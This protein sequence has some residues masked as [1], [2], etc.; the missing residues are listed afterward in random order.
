M[1]SRNNFLNTKKIAISVFSILALFCQS[2]SGEIEIIKKGGVL[3]VSGTVEDSVEK[4]QINFM[5]SRNKEISFYHEVSEFNPAY[6]PGSDEGYTSQWDIFYPVVDMALTPNMYGVARF[7]EPQTTVYSVN[8]FFFPEQLELDSDQ[9]KIENGKLL[10]WENNVYLDECTSPMDSFYLAEQVDVSNTV[11]DRKFELLA[12]DWSGIIEVVSLPDKKEILRT[13]ILSACESNRDRELHEPEG[14]SLNR[15]RLLKSLTATIDFTLRSQ[16]KSENSRAK[17]GLNLFY[18]LKAKTFRRPTWIW[19]WGPSIKLLLDAE[20]IPEISKSYSPGCLAD[21]AKE[22]GETTLKFQENDVKSPAF[23]LIVSRWS[24]T[25]DTLIQ[26]SGYEKYY[27]VADAQFLAGW[28]WM[29]LYERTKDER[30]L[31]GTRRLT[32]ATER[33]MKEHDFLPMDYKVREGEWKNYA[34]NEQG[35]GTLATAELH[36]VEP[37]ER[38]QQIV[39]DYM[40]MLSGKFES[41]SGLWNRKVL[42][43]ENEIIPTAYKPK[44]QGWVAEGL[45]AVYETTQDKTYLLKAEKI[46]D[47]LVEYQLPEGAWSL[48]FTEKDSSHIDEKA[49]AIWSFLFYRLYHHTEDATY[50]AA[51]RK[52]LE[53][54]LNNQYFGEDAQARGGIVGVSR[55]SGVIYRRWFPLQCIYTSGFFGLAVLEELALQDHGN[56]QKEGEAGSTF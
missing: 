30:Y 31:E 7:P 45:L 29:P 9:I 44:S 41:E 43:D 14:T 50:L 38:Y 32:E 1:N 49:V 55:I 28:A 4:V 16:D 36:K 2:S 52:A 25:Q 23:G 22:I 53:W 26:T 47:Y 34:L 33:I 20:K 56:K 6:N 21:I 37:G 48:D 13:E 46:A 12:S 27:S 17:N 35:F 19:S 39:T 8:G 54:C 51:G 11:L 15:K 40:E 3:V 10:L 18:D 42:I 24:E 5:S